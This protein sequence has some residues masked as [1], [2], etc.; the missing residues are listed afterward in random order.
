[1][2][3]IIILLPLSNTTQAKNNNYISN[4]E[5]L[6]E[7]PYIALPIG[8]I[9]PKGGLGRQVKLASKG[10]TGHLDEIWKDVAIQWKESGH[11]SVFL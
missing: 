7:N 5:P 3:I 10:M 4:R 1:M 9:E 8:S 11:W 6:I 2:L